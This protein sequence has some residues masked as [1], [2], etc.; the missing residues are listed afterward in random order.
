MKHLLN[1]FI[2]TGLSFSIFCSPVIAARKSKVPIT[3]E[4]FHGYTGSIEYMKAVN[5]AYPEITD[6][7]E[8]GKSSQ[9]RPIYVLVIT[10]KNTGTTLDREK[11]LRHERK[12]EVPNPPITP[13]DLG[14]AGHMITGATHGNE[15]TG[16]EVC[17]YF[18]DKMV[19]GYKN[20]SLTTTLIDTK[21]F[22]VC[23]VNNPD[24]LYN[25]VEIGIPQR[26]N[27]M[28]QGKEKPLRK[29]L[30][31]DGIF[32]LMRYKDPKGDFRKDSV[33]SRVMVKIN[34]D[35]NTPD[36]DRYAVVSEAEPDKGID[37]NR[38]FP[39]AWWKEDAFPGGSGDF[40]T[41]APESQ[42]LCEFI[43]QHPNIIMVNEYHTQGGYVYRPLGSAPDKDMQPRDVAVYD[44]IMGK[45]YIELMGGKMPVAWEKPS[46]IE[47][48]KDELR[49][50]KDIFVAARGYEFPYEWKVPY[51]KEKE[52]KAY[53]GLYLDWLYKQCGI[54]SLVTEL[55]N[56]AHDIDELKGLKGIELQ[57]SLLKYLDNLKE[58]IYLEWTPAKHPEHG[59]V[60]VGGWVGNIGGNNAFPG[61][62]LDSICERQ[63]QFD[64]FRSS[65]MPQMA[66]NDIKV[67]TQSAGNAKV[68]EIT[69]EIENT[70]ALP[71]GLVGTEWMA[72]N[73]G[74]VVW[75]A[76]E[77]NKITFLMGNPYEK[78][79]NLYGSMQIPGFESKDGNKKIVKWVVSVEGNE[80]IKVIA[81][82]LKGGT[83]VKEVKY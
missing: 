36:S 72:F 10:N 19:S 59:N 44:L 8:I 4:K 33:D 56:P 28:L 9:G 66:I 1:F 55:W 73:R 47:H 57:R 32:S 82:S 22:Y 15:Q 21:A 12:L 74:D 23:P 13:K 5:K 31:N 48:C 58:K 24:G 38:N 53:Y 64:L 81:S 2:C 7:L 45:K 43:I 40:P 34:K 37:I 63:W 3:F 77:N 35:E 17:L 78:I 68:L 79:G 60:E 18:I 49:L 75:L 76:G 11:K 50:S 14:K 6:L 61:A 39:E 26:T 67:K 54:Y 69:A 30:N 42:A 27:S 71:S 46:K 51:S 52:K 29:D 83:V 80:K 16:T 25:T 62:I 41:S 70:G 65:L 20:D